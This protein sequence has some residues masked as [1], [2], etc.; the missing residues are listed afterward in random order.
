M[1]IT[2]VSVVGIEWGQTSFEAHVAN[3]GIK[4][5]QRC[6]ICNPV[7]NVLVI[8]MVIGPGF[9]VS[10]S[11]FLHSAEFECSRAGYSQLFR[12]GKGVESLELRE[13]AFAFF[14]GIWIMAVCFGCKRQSSMDSFSLILLQ[15]AA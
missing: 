11:K 10:R 15:Y 9:A 14:G 8:Q 1:S 5:T 3:L 7:F 13:S 2:Q 6:S 4:G 12:N